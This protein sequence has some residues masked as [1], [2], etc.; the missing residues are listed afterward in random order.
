MN[1]QRG[2]VLK[3]VEERTDSEASQSASESKNS[4]DAKTSGE[5]LE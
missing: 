2:R 5:D 3:E 1:L 4:S